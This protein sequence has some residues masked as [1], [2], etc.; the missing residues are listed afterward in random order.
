M[1]AWPTM[2]YRPGLVYA[3]RAHPDFVRRYHINARRA[4]ERSGFHFLEDRA[5]LVDPHR[6]LV[7]LAAHR[8]L[9]YDVLFLASGTDP[10]WNA[11]PGLNVTRGG[12]CE[13]YLAR[14]TAA[15]LQNWQSGTL[16]LA[17]G[18]LKASPHAPVQLA[19]A[20]EFMLYEAALLWDWECRRRRVRHH[21]QIVLA[22]PAPV[23][24]EPLGPSGRQHIAAIM[25]SRD[26]QIKTQAQYVE[27][28][29]DGLQLN[30]GFVSAHAMIWVP[31]YIGSGLAR[32]SGLDDG[33]GWVPVTPH[34]QHR[35]WPHIYAVGDITTHVPKIAHAA[36][37]QARVA[38]HHWWSV[39]HQHPLPPPYHPQ[40]IA[41]IDVG[42]GQG[43]FSLN[44]TLYGGT[45]DISYV[46]WPAQLAKRIFNHTYICGQGWLPV[47]P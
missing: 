40:V 17:C 15:T 18:P 47:M 3:M 43:F 39:T 1:D 5:V 31:P 29:D 42:S 14:H 46:G 44:T 26:I 16:L 41:L 4:A 22:T 25:A 6:Q 38:V 23:L 30:R 11:I 2:T 9:Q 21:T 37:V 13:D 24:G 19:T 12:L 32:N 45:R 20:D 34:L 33:Y 10:G 28:R 27:V 35:R 36:M 7:E 8:P